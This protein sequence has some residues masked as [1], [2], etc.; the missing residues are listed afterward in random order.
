ME[1]GEEGD[2]CPFQRL[3]EEEKEAALPDTRLWQ[4]WVPGLKVWDFSFP[5]FVPVCFLV[6]GD[7]WESLGDRGLPSWFGALLGFSLHKRPWLVLRWTYAVAA[8]LRGWPRSA[9][10]ICMFHAAKQ[11]MGF[12][13]FSAVCISS[14]FVFRS[15]NTALIYI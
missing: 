7:L 9:H 10:G 15:V 11:L 6:L 4:S 3:G 5:S 14:A 12:P 8:G 1:D 13:I 2:L